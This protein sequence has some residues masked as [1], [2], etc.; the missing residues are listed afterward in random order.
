MSHLLQLLLELLFLDA[1]EECDRLLYSITKIIEIIIIWA[2]VNVKEGSIEIVSVSLA[3]RSL[4]SR[5]SYRRNLAC[6]DI[7]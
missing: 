1:T 7:K 5:Q 6:I 4:L 2:V 3:V